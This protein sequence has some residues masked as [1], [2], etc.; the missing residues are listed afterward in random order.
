M[1]G[2]TLLLALALAVTPLVDADEK[3]R[4]SLVSIEWPPFTDDAPAPRFALD[5]VRV[6]LGHAGLHA[7]TTIVPDGE[8]IPSLREGRYEGSAALWRDE[9]RE[10]F[11]LYS[12]PYLENRLMLVGLKG[13]DVSATELSAL[14]GRRVGTVTGYSYGAEVAGASGVVFVEGATLQANLRDLLDGAIDYML[15]DELVLQHIVEAY[16]AQCEEKLAI[17]SYPL[18]RRTLHFALR[19]DVADA[20]SIIAAFNEKIRTMLADGTYNRILR[21]NWIEA[22]VDGDGAVELVLH[23]DH[24]GE[25]SPA[26]AYAALPGS[27][28]E[29]KLRFIVGGKVYDDWNNVPDRYKI[30]DPARHDPERSTANLVK[31]RW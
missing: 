24:A 22:D 20:A 29:G 17:G 14:E 21:L 6:G 16:A 10:R 23:G 12:E 8:L 30:S 2:T 28:K 18:V 4:L 13:S 3:R 25:S 19:R 31:I 11:L 9:Q 5:L 27:A 15:V 1:K 7:G 26:G